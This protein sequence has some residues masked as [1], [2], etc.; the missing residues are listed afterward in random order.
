MQA[1]LILA[2]KNFDQIIELSQRLRPIFNIY[3]HVDKK[4][5]LTNQQKKRFDELNV[6]Y[7]S[8]YDVKWGSYSIVRATIDM[9]ELALSDSQNKYFHLISGQDWPMQSPQA[10]YNAFENTD[11]I[12]MNYWRMLDMN[13]SGEPEIWWVKYYFNYDQINRRTTFGKI[14]HRFLLLFQTIFRINKLKKYKLSPEKM[15]AGQE[16]VDIPRDALEY[17]IT[18]YHQH[19]ELENTFS[20]SFCSDEMWLQTVL[21]N[22]KFRARIDKNIRHYIRMTSKHGHG[23][24]PAVLDK[25]DF[26][27]INTGDYWWGRKVIRPQSNQLIELL[28]KKN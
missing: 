2:H 26:N 10:I 28:D 7:F 21:C 5:E 20:T 9:M 8:K 17:A 3:M 1:V 6:H 24:Q 22:S 12:Y 23:I 19:P 14:Y 11:K 25:S 13:K 15:Y 27:K 4:V 18:Y 16:W